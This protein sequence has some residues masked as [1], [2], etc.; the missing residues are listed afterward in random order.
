MFDRSP[1]D[2]PHRGWKELSG[3]VR[4]WLCR[5][6]WP[7][8]NQW[9]GLGI[10][11]LVYL[12]MQ[13]VSRFGPFKDWASTDLLHGWPVTIAI[14][15]AV[16]VTA[17]SPLR[18]RSRKAMVAH[19]IV[20]GAA[21]WWL[22]FFLSA[23]DLLV[24]NDRL[25]ATLLLI[26]ILAA[27]GR[28][29]IGQRWVDKLARRSLEN[30]PRGKRVVHVFRMLILGP[31]KCGLNHPLTPAGSQLTW[32]PVHLYN[33]VRTKVGIGPSRCCAI[34]KAIAETVDLE[35]SQ[36]REI[37]DSPKPLD[38]LERAVMRSVHAMG[39]ELE[40]VSVLITVGIVDKSDHSRWSHRVL[41]VWDLLRMAERFTGSILAD[42]R[43]ELLEAILPLTA[44][45]RVLQQAVCAM[46]HGRLTFEDVDEIICRPPRV[47]DMRES[48]AAILMADLLVELELATW[49]LGL[50]GCP[51]MSIYEDWLAPSVER[52]RLEAHEQILRHEAALE[53]HDCVA[54]TMQAG[55]SMVVADAPSPTV[56]ETR[57]KI[58]S[59]NGAAFGSDLKPD[60]MRKGTRDVAGVARPLFD[61]GPG[62]VISAAVLATA[63]VLFVALATWVTPLPF[64]STFKELEDLYR[65]VDYREH[66]LTATDQDPVTG[67]ILMTSLGGGLHEVDPDT[68]RIRTERSI[69]GL[70]SNF[71]TDVA[72]SSTGQL[73]VLTNEVSESGGLLG[74]R[75]ADVRTGRDWHTLIPA[76]G[77]GEVADSSLTLVKALGP[78]K[79][80]LLGTRLFVY[81]TEQRELQELLPSGEGIPPDSQVTAAAVSGDDTLWLAVKD[82][83]G[84]SR[85]MEVRLGTTSYLTSDI[86]TPGIAVE[87]IEQLA[88]AGDTLLARTRTNRLFALADGRW[89]L[90]LDGESDLDLNDIRHAIV[91]PGEP[92]ALWLTER[93]SSGD[94]ESIR[95]R[96]LPTDRV[97][98]R[99]AWRRV[100]LGN[101]T[102]TP[103]DASEVL[104]SSKVRLGPDDPSPAA[105]FNSRTNE[106]VLLVP[107]AGPGVWTLSAPVAAP[108]SFAEAKLT[109]AFVSTGDFHLLSADVYGGQMVLALENDMQTLR[110]VVSCPVE[111]LSSYLAKAVI[112]QQNYLPDPSLAD[113]RLVAARVTEKGKR[114]ELFTDL[115]TAAIYNTELHGFQ[116]SR[117]I[118]VLDEAEKQISRLRNADL[119]ANRLLLCERSGRVL[120]VE[121]PEMCAS[122]SLLRARTIHRAPQSR[123]TAT[124]LPVRIATEAGGVDLLMAA[125]GSSLAWPW[126]LDV[127]ASLP[128][129]KEQMQAGMSSLIALEQLKVG[130]PLSIASLTRLQER[131]LIGR[132]VAL[133][134]RGE[135]LW[136]NA[137]GWATVN[138]PA[139]FTP[140]QEIL[141]VAGATLVRGQ[142][143]LIRL[144]Q[145]SDTPVLRETLWS[146]RH[147][148]IELPVSAV[149]AL[150]DSASPSILVGHQGGLSRYAPLD[151]SWEL[152]SG[153]LPSLDAAEVSWQFAGVEATTG[154]CTHL[155][156]LRTE[157]TTQSGNT[158][159]VFL[160]KGGRAFDVAGGAVQSIHGAGEFLGIVYE[161]GRIDVAAPDG[162][163][164]PLVPP[165]SEE[166]G[167]VDLVRVANA[168][169][170]YAVDDRGRLLSAE[171][172]VAPWQIE[173]PLKNSRPV[174]DIV[175]TKSGQLIVATQD[176]TVYRKGPL[177]TRVVERDTSRLEPVGDFVAAADPPSGRL[178]LLTTDQAAP[179]SLAGGRLAPVNIGAPVSKVLM[180][181]DQ[182]FVAGSTGTA[183]RDPIRRRFYQLSDINGASEF[184]KLGMH[185]IA[186]AGDQI[187]RLTAERYGSVPKA[188]AIGPSG[189]DVVLGPAGKLWLATRNLNSTEDARTGGTAASEHDGIS[190]AE[191][192]WIESIDG[193]EE[194]LFMHQGRLESP[195]QQ[196]ARLSTHEVL[197]R[198]S[199]GE[200]LHYDLRTR[201]LVTLKAAAELPSNW[202]LTSSETS[203]LL[204]PED[205]ATTRRKIM[206]IS[207]SPPEVRLVTGDA[208]HILESAEAV[209]YVTE[210]GKVV[211]LARDGTAA[212]LAPLATRTRDATAQIKVS[213]ALAE[214][215]EFFCARLGSSAVRYSLQE[216]RITDNLF[217]VNS[218]LR[219][220]GSI[221]GHVNKGDGR[222]E[223]APLSP[224]P[225][226]VRL[227]THSVTS[228]GAGESGFV[229]WGVS[230]GMLQASI[231]SDRL[232]VTIENQ[233]HPPTGFGPF[234]KENLVSVD[235]RFVYSVSA[236]GAVVS[237]DAARGHW[238]T[239]SGLESGFSQ[240][241][242]LGKT[243]AAVRRTEGNSEVLLI[244]SGAGVY[245]RWSIPGSNV[246]FT[247]YGVVR[248][249]QPAPGRVTV[250]IDL[251]DGSS[252]ELDRFDRAIDPFN[253]GI[254]SV[255]EL[256]T[257]QRALLVTRTTDHQLKFWLCDTQ[258]QF[259]KITKPLFSNDAE[260]PP[261]FG[262]ENQF[263]LLNDAGRLV[264]INATS[265]AVAESQPTL[266]GLGAIGGDVWLVEPKRDGPGF[267]VVRAGDGK[268]LATL[269]SDDDRTFLGQATEAQFVLQA[270]ENS[271]LLRV[272]PAR[273][274]E[275]AADSILI[276][277]PVQGYR[278]ERVTWAGYAKHRQ[279]GILPNSAVN[280][281]IEILGSQLD[282][283]GWL[284][285]HSILEFDEI[286]AG[287]KQIPLRLRDG[288]LK[289]LRVDET[290][291]SRPPRSLEGFRLDGTSLLGA[292][293]ETHYGAI[294]QS[295]RVLSSD[296]WL[297]ARPLSDGRIVSLDGFGQLWLWNLEAGRAKRNRVAA[298]TPESSPKASRFGLPVSSDGS[299][300]LLNES[301]SVVGRFSD[302]GLAALSPRSIK[303]AV[304]SPAE[305]SG[306]AGVLKWS[307]SVTGDGLSLSLS[308]ADGAGETVEVP[309]EM[310]AFGLDVDTP[311]DLVSLPD[312]GGVWLHIANAGTG[313]RVV[314]PAV[315][316]G[317]LQRAKVVGTF[318]KPPAPQPF[319]VATLR[320]IP[321]AGRWFMELEGR[322]L[323]L[324]NGI[325]AMDEIRSAASVASNGDTLLYLHTGLANALV[326]QKWIAEGTLGPPTL[327]NAPDG[328]RSLRIWQGKLAAQTSGNQWQTFDGSKWMTVKPDWTSAVG[329]ATPW[330]F[331]GQN[332]Q[333]AWRGRHLGT[334]GDDSSDFA[335]A[336]DVLTPETSNDGAPHVRLSAAG[337]VVYQSASGAWFRWVV[338][339]A[340]SQELAGS[341]PPYTQQTLDIAGSSLI[342]PSRYPTGGKYQLKQSNGAPVTLPLELH[343]GRLPHHHVKSIE[344]WGDQG[345]QISLDA[346]HGYL[347]FDERALQN[348][349][350][351]R[352]EAKELSHPSAV[353]DYTS[354]VRCS[355]S[356][357]STLAW[358]PAFQFSWKHPQ[359]RI[360]MPLGELTNHGFA[361][362]D[363]TKV[364]P[365]EL[366]GDRLR[367]AMLGRVWYRPLGPSLLDFV[368]SDEK[369]PDSP[370]QIQI[371]SATGRVG[372]SLAV[373]PG[374]VD[375]KM[376]GAFTSAGVFDASASFRATIRQSG[377]TFSARL[378][379]DAPVPVDLELTRNSSGWSVPFQ[380]PLAAIYQRDL[381]VMLS[382]DGRTVGVWGRDG[383]LTAI[384]PVNHSLA[385]LWRNGDRVESRAPS[386]G[387]D[388][389]IGATESGLPVSRVVQ[390]SPAP[391]DLVTD[392]F[393]LR[394]NRSDGRFDVVWQAAN[395][396]P[397]LP[398]VSWSRGGIPGSHIDSCAWLNPGEVAMADRYGVRSLTLAD[399]SF[400]RTHSVLGASIDES[401]AA[402]LASVVLRRRGAQVVAGSIT[403]PLRLIS[404]SASAPELELSPVPLDFGSE[405][406]GS[407][408]IAQ[409]WTDQ[410]VQ[411]TATTSQEGVVSLAHTLAGKFLIDRATFLGSVDNRSFAVVP[412]G[413]QWLDSAPEFLPANEEVSAELLQP[414][415][416]L[417][418]T[419]SGAISLST[420]DE[421]RVVRIEQRLEIGRPPAGSRE[422]IYVSGLDDWRAYRHSDGVTLARPVETPQGPLIDEI[423]TENLLIGGQLAFDHVRA[424]SR[425]PDDETRLLLQTGRGIESVSRSD[426]APV[427]STH[428]LDSKSFH[429]APPWRSIPV[430]F[431]PEDQGQAWLL[432]LDE[433]QIRLRRSVPT[434]KSL[435]GTDPAPRFALDTGERLWIAFGDGMYWLE[436]GPRWRGRLYREFGVGR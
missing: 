183:W 118:P 205:T 384:G 301:G 310:T 323:D 80:L 95:A 202:R 359:T 407:W 330:S 55:L 70:S 324:R 245:D 15:I 237:Y 54:R 305:R 133:N 421:S 94:I 88:V 419:P 210:S 379:R 316:Q 364:H 112:L 435:L 369:A 267:T 96:V 304:D 218:L 280:G 151:R 23:A 113:S 326:R 389:V 350:P 161:N 357:G 153:T 303:A 22:F 380:H 132:Q 338:N 332:S 279:R 57:K 16:A 67:T 262:D 34:E 11:V 135:L 141:S 36:L 244:R 87:S 71:L 223:L 92:P 232:A 39:A 307:R 271:L 199:A 249:H 317:R 51:L 355:F 154:V 410:P 49:A 412:T 295:A 288:S 388:V 140:W 28:L 2:R 401:S 190:S 48:L 74:A 396:T 415:L 32:L 31:Q 109:V 221:V 241:G 121:L 392:S 420:G 177:E 296:L 100:S 432:K 404:T 229:A 214:N 38:F 394:R 43:K 188:K 191:C 65:L 37:I 269:L 327:V 105:W 25:F 137:E 58:P 180:D 403:E 293:H 134:A 115:G 344:S 356:N 146:G 131:Q 81:R 315:K 8:R 59:L 226:G 64:L 399:R 46:Q 381:I 429:R 163:V 143:G 203:V 291:A 284:L 77:V 417:L 402:G 361:H 119:A 86:S 425:D 150:A 181:G 371:D 363:P 431:R 368:P 101:G 253:P 42:S 120:E 167:T 247:R 6:R 322:S 436:T 185:R 30:D 254:S 321:R 393:G 208:G 76:R 351:P 225:E 336:A 298:P 136:R 216:C 306:R 333:L 345:L 3:I 278:V 172:A 408:K 294:D 102:A 26:G 145:Q 69:A 195:P 166:V 370:Q 282:G 395:E 19:G 47:D 114:V 378:K 45:S 283:A 1:H 228:V 334:I 108:E 128:I 367:F 138:E 424:V 311:L 308:V 156:A 75:G 272:G 117:A 116:S 413:V 260:P 434:A 103:A 339:D 159:R 233:V 320:F 184:I 309:A 52:V 299:L 430:S 78:D 148:V 382:Q 427:L 35:S 433:R 85:I 264:T 387:L 83:K 182:L 179:V 423:P 319:D 66:P 318:A 252:Q 234:A 426:V 274:N 335:F 63:A 373:S 164:R 250:N 90:Q 178:S 365:L 385:T 341:P 12:S 386:N 4:D 240:I 89:Q 158:S 400:T 110:R 217:D 428:R 107:A 289:T 213:Q 277:A 207:G 230:G 414:P 129:D 331:D 124:M 300:L 328:V 366:E 397:W 383:S 227:P 290:V 362:D 266:R 391:P 422:F 376:L 173:P 152:I 337:E 175:A 61:P 238:Q 204:L 239:V 268:E 18:T 340:I 82:A 222:G 125:A 20:M 126:H 155:W 170:L 62:R 209:A 343:Q 106:H 246:W 258:H 416:R 342:I 197:F 257:K 215:D 224:L 165:T 127:T 196:A 104:L 411:V 297:D 346:N 354:H 263:Y 50:L 17:S 374:P 358:S 98:P 347:A 130:Y 21:L 353:P 193:S 189:S 171:T 5:L 360:E 149:A 212:E 169:R 270:D 40:V 219:V 275:S 162:S 220:Q 313:R 314:V 142:A 390:R 176:G 168:D 10:V 273:G 242:T 123:P 352:H 157:K 255:Y 231:V 206:Q 325:P 372:W 377:G 9:Y 248:L 147:P 187:F 53:R 73:A 72:V 44:E 56:S 192:K 235:G 91:S 256:P 122:E 276:S 160:C 398:T 201:S 292:D 13:V 200:L 302:E 261:I 251:I 329:D 405:Q 27:V 186:W 406:A 7:H 79:L 84:C 139:A 236:S 281:L 259:Q 243:I 198:G 349:D 111:E 211:S 14:A 144:G 348:I 265:G 29:L 409:T 286:A 93:G 285:E 60:A 375:D 174:V 194:P 33:V 68:F 418:Q 41:Q 97:L 24:R 312:E 287:L 99:S